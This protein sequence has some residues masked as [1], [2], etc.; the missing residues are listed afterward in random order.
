MFMCLL[1]EKSV[2]I[3]LMKNKKKIPYP[4]LEIG[5]RGPLALWGKEPFK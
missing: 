4:L 1:D 2:D 5:G 3:D